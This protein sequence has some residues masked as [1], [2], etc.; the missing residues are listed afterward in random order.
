MKTRSKLLNP[1][2]ECQIRRA[3]R[4]PQ[5]QRAQNK[6]LLEKM[7]NVQV[8]EVVVVPEMEQRVVVVVDAEEEEVV[9]AQMEL[10]P[11]M[12]HLVYQ[13][14]DLT[15]HPRLMVVKDR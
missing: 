4:E 15:C 10:Q 8:A 12:V 9:E 11:A 3:K 7:E 2:R 14:K 6:A 1:A 13:T 5:I